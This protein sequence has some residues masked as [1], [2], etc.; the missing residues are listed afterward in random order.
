MF[1]L[2]HRLCAVVHVLFY[3][4]DYYLNGLYLIEEELSI[5]EKINKE[6][7]EIAQAF[8]E[9]FASQRRVLNKV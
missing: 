4:M 6:T 1:Y 5:P 8:V 3:V 2:F 9:Y 7:A